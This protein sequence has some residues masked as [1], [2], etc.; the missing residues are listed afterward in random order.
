MKV[1]LVEPGDAEDLGY[2][3]KQAGATRFSTQPTPTPGYGSTVAVA[4]Q[5]G[6]VMYSDLQG[7]S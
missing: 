1:P 4:D 5:Y 3:W 6:V 2:F 7:V